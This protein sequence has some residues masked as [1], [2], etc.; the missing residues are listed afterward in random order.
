MLDA[1]PDLSKY[2]GNLSSKQN[3]KDSWKNNKFGGPILDAKNNIRKNIQSEEFFDKFEK[4]FGFYVLKNVKISPKL[5][6]FWD[7]FILITSPI[8]KYDILC[9]IEHWHQ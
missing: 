5:N 6:I 7:I 3:I 2:K 9:K 1:Y 8:E 4:G